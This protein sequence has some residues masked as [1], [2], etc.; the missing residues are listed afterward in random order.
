MEEPRKNSH[1][2]AK[3]NSLI[4]KELGIIL[5]EFLVGQNALV[6]ITKVETSG[7]MRWSKIWISALGGDE[8]KILQ[9]LKDNIYDI[10]GEMNQKFATKI[11][12]RL[13]FFLDTS[14]KYAQHIDEVLKKIKEDS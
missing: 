9:F 13:Q 4:E 3:V 6:T 7:D 2:I 14:G 11:I 5:R 1:R 10:Q 8:D 12:P